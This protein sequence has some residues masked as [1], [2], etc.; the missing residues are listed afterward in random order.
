M[1]KQEILKT[2][3]ALKPQLRAQFKVQ[4]ISLFGSFVRGEQ[5]ETS[6]IDVLVEFNQDASF[7][8]LVRL[9]NFLEERFQ[10]RV[11]VI[12]QESLRAEIRETVLRERVAV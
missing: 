7:F 12:P 11:D 1:S 4:E 10:R 5:A 2:L 8:D 3:H 9:G 6:D